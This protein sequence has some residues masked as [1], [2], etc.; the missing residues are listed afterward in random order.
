[1][2]DCAQC[3]E[4]L[5]IKLLSQLTRQQL[6]SNAFEVGAIKYCIHNTFHRSNL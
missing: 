1:M 3:P 5:R 6:F 2:A 4:C